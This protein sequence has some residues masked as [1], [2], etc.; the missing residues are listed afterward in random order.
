[1]GAQHGN[2]QIHVTSVSADNVGTAATARHHV[3]YLSHWNVVRHP[4]F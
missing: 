4:L 3:T 1:M 2:G